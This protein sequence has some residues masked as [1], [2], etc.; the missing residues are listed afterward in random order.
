MREGIGPRPG[1]H[2]AESFSKLS[3]SGKSSAQWREIAY[4]EWFLEQREWWP[5]DWVGVIE[6]RGWLEDFWE[7]K[8]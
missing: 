6:R 1:E 4:A 8:P 3:D 2:T 7:S 5:D